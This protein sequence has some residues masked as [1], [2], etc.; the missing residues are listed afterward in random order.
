MATK[1]EAQKKLEELSKTY[2]KG[3]KL[4]EHKTNIPYVVDKLDLDDYKEGWSVVIHLTCLVKDKQTNA[5]FSYSYV[6]DNFDI[7][8]SV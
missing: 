1:E 7:D 6:E 8:P 4:K 3:T 5:V 2:K